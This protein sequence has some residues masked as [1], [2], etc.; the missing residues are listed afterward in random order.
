M[1]LCESNG[2]ANVDIDNSVAKTQLIKCFGTNK[3]VG[4]EDRST[5]NLNLRQRTR[6]K[7]NQINYGGIRNLET[8][9]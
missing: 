7:G 1:I 8:N 6:N 3:I 2:N 4:D 5:T 9:E